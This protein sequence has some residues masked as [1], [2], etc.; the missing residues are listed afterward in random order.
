[1]A[2][3]LAIAGAFLVMLLQ[4]FIWKRFWSR[5]LSAQVEFD[6]GAVTEG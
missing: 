5:G 4:R 3:V 6:R 1:M 2:V